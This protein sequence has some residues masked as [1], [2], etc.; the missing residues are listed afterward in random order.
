VHAGRGFDRE[1]TIPELLETALDK[2]MLASGWTP[3]PQPTVGDFAYRRSETGQTFW[4]TI[5]T[6]GELTLGPVV[7]DV[8][9]GG[10]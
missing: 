3:Q 2:E 4:A 9:T 5:T 10:T 7:L 1:G 6:G 8:T